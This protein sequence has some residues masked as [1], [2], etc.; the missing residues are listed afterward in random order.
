MSD[1]GLLYEF[2]DELEKHEP[3]M[4]R[5]FTDFTERTLTVAFIDEI[6]FE[7]GGHPVTSHL[8]LYQRA[9]GLSDI[10]IDVTKF[11]A[12]PRVVIREYVGPNAMLGIDSVLYTKDVT[13]SGSFLDER[14]RVSIPPSLSTIPGL[15]LYQGN[16]TDIDTPRFN[17]GMHGVGFYLTGWHEYPA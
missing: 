4:G 17:A 5:P 14:Y 2:V 10:E 9:Y 13:Q 7:R 15:T 1:V 6:G 3:D 8:K 12:Q 11:Y 16:A